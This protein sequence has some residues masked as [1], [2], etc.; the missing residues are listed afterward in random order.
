MRNQLED[1]MGY[2]SVLFST[3]SN[4]LI[5]VAQLMG[6]LSH[7]FCLILLVQEVIF[8]IKQVSSH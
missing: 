1:Q 6:D 2:C 4:F 3:V 7:S 8:L 5:L